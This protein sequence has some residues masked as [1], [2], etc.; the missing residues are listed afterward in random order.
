MPKA[1]VK[2]SAPSAA[3]SLDASNFIERIRKIIP[4]MSDE[5]TR[6]YLNGVYFSHSAGKLTLAATDGHRLQ[7]QVFN[8]RGD[9]P[10]FNFICPASV[11]KMLP[12][13]FEDAAFVSI[14][15]AEGR[16]QFSFAGSEYTVKPIGGRFP[17]YE[18]LIPANIKTSHGFNSTYLRDVL[19]S[20]D[21]ASVSFAV[22]GENIFGPEPHLVISESNSDIRC[23]IMPMRVSTR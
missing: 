2:E 12:V 14:A 6:Y 7:E 13:L 15:F 20:F 17:E 18:K 11:I 21:G 22:D 3:I 1:V 4:F 5:E 19:S 8:V 10:D 9:A 16:I 23:I